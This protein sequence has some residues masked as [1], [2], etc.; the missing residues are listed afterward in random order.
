MKVLLDTH[1]LIWYTE[2][3]DKLS[4]AA[5]LEIDNPNNSKFISIGS[6]WEIVIKSSQNKLELIKS[7][8]DIKEFLSINYIQI[9]QI[10]TG[11]L[12]ILFNLPHHH[13]DPFDRLLIAQAIAEDMTL[14][15]V[16]AHFEA[17]PV[18]IIGTGETNKIINSLSIGEIIF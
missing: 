7:F 5:K 12:K 10:E 2:G 16:D 6:L 18:N 15:S 17:Y 8:D 4:V 9:L 13:R 14:I 3:S 1:A 11:H